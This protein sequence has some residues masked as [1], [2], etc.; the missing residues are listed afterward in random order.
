MAQIAG[1]DILVGLYD[2]TT[3]GLT[4]SDPS[5]I[6]LAY[7][8]LGVSASQE[9][10]VND[11]ITSGR[12]VSRP[13]KGNIDVTG[14]LVTT[15]APATCAFFLKHI[16]GEPTAGV[17]TPGALPPGFIIE[18][19]YT[20]KVA[21]RV[22]RFNG[23]RVKSATFTFNQSGYV[24][25]SI[26]I[27]GKRYGIY[28]E[29]LDSALTE[30]E[31]EAW[32]GFQ[33]IVKLNGV[34]IG[35]VMS[36]SVTIDNEIDTSMYAFPGPDDTP[37]ERMS[38]PEGLA[39]ITGQ[40]EVVF[41]NFDLIDI[42]NAGTAVSLE[43]VYTNADGKK[44]T[45]AITPCEIPLT[46]PTIESRSG[47][48]VTYSFS[49]FVNEAAEGLT[50]TLID[51]EILTD[52]NTQVSGVSSALN[53][54]AVGASARVAVGAGGVILR[55]TNGT[56]WATQTSGL[57]TALNAV[58]WGG[59]QFVAVGAA[60][61]ILTS[62]DGETWTAQTSGLATALQG[63]C[64]SSGLYVAVGDSGK[65]LT[66]TNGTAWTERSSGATANLNAVA[67]VVNLFV[68]V[69]V[70]GN[71]LTSPDGTTWTKQTSGITAYHAV[72]PSTDYFVIGGAGGKIITSATGASGTWRTRT[73]GLTSTI[74]GLDKSSGTYV[75]VADGGNIVVSYDGIVWLERDSGVTAN[76]LAVDGVEGA[77][78]VC[79]ASGTVLVAS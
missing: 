53:N 50:V 23:C 46:S 41:E 60:G 58:I 44:I 13:G 67:Y 18:K 35:G 70:A 77:F 39:K 20:S 72:A 71:I 26:D 31:H 61:A 16:F 38:L 75:A 42:A 54:V 76:L 15:F 19:D 55:S 6:V 14:S 48:K 79:G 74:R 22:E 29:V 30:Y 21:S 8:S 63:V 73:S 36:G 27:A 33:G 2:E 24:D 56:T 47:L 49:A 9:S 4:P 62:P 78:T 25:L 64:Y 12:G 3:F 52:W 7:K 51:A 57:A 10:V 69:G 1:T 32:T 28:P 40:M 5:G 17:Y 59:S 66:S 45:F 65:I 68:A 11:I 34:R 43:W 37:G